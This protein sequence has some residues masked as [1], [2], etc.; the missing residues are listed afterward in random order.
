MLVGFAILPLL[1]ESLFPE[2]KER[3][4]LSHCITKPGTSIEE[5][6]RIATQVSNEV[7]AIEGCPQFRHPHRHGFT[8]G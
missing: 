5:E 1:G 4:F 7:R 2:F 3:D 6:R 8:G